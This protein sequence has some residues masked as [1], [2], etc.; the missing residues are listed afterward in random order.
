MQGIARIRSFDDGAAV[1]D[2]V[3]WQTHILSLDGLALLREL[4]E[5]AIE[6]PSEAPF[7]L[8]E[9]FLS[10]VP[11]TTPTAELKVCAEIA[12]HLNAGEVDD[13]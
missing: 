9:R 10:A 8:I 3:T 11:G 6:Y 2:P 1:F 7:P 5:I 4:L 12:Y 13:F